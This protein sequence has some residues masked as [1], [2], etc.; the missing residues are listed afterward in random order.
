[1]AEMQDQE[2]GL[3]EAP[4]LLH[5]DPAEIES[6]VPDIRQL[7]TKGELN[8]DA[9]QALKL[10]MDFERRGAEF[11]HEFA[12]K[13]IDTQGKYILLHFAE[14]ETN[15]YRQMAQRVEEAASVPSA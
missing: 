3:A 9:R 6:L 13:F 12:E 4:I 5:F 7:E 14:E 2:K 8:I 1:L 11:F 10:S 15:H